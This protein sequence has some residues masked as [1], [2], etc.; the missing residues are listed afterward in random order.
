[1]ALREQ[2][3]TVFSDLYRSLRQRIEE[4]SGRNYPQSS[5]VR[6]L[7]VMR[8]SGL[9]RTYLDHTSSRGRSPVYYVNEDSMAAVH[10]AVLNDLAVFARSVH[11]Q[12]R[13]PLTT[14]SH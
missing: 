10:Q 11:E 4:E 6:V 12:Q 13:G 9:L 14:S 2:P 7:T 1:M 3:G 8:A 5:L